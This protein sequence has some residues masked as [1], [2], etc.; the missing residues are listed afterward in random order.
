M[1]AAAAP[2]PLQA[3]RLAARLLLA[4]GFWTLWLALALLL[5]AQLYIASTDELSLPGFVRRS[6]EARLAASGIRATFGRTHFDPTGRIVVENLA[7]TLPGYSEPQVTARAVVGRIDPWQLLGDRFEPVE[8][9]VTGLSVHVPGLLSL[10]GGGDQILRDV[11]AALV[12]RGDELK[13]SYLTGR[14]GDMPVSLQGTLR[15][16]LGGWTKEGPAPLPVAE[17]LAR[18]YPQLSRQ[19]EAALAGLRTFD[20]PV[21][22]VDLASAAGPG[23][24]ARVDFAA[25]SYRSDAPV[26]VRLT[27]LRV[28]GEAQ[29][30]GDAPAPA[31]IALTAGAGTFSA[32]GTVEELAAWI[33]GSLAGAGRAAGAPFLRLQAAQLVAVRIGAAGLGVDRPIA[34]VDLA[35]WPRIGADLRGLL[36]DQRIA[37]QADV[38]PGA[39]AARVRFSGALASPAIDFVGRQVHRDLRTLVAYSTP[40][41]A[42]GEAQFGPA[43]KFARAAA[44]IELAGLTARGVRIDAAHGS[45]EFDGRTLRS[46]DAFAQLGENFARG[47]FTE[48]VASHDYRFLLEGRLRP[49]DITPWIAGAWWPEFFGLFDFSAE[50]VAANADIRGCFTD[51]RQAAD[52][53]EVTVGQPGFRGLKFDRL[54]ARIFSRPQF[55]DGLEFELSRGGGTASGTFARRYDLDAGALQSLDLAVQSTLDLAPLGPLLSASGSP[56]LDAFVF[57]RPPQVGLTAHFDGQAAPA[58][59][60]EVLRLDVRT[61]EPISYNDFPFDRIAFV[62]EVNDADIRLPKLE[63]KVAGGT[64]TGSARVWGD[65]AARRLKVDAALADASLGQAIA[66]VQEFSARRAHRPSTPPTRFVQ[67]KTS[68]RVNAT[69]AAEGNFGDALSL[70]GDGTIALDGEN[71]HQIRLLGL[72]SALLPVTELRFTA[73]RASFRLDGPRLVFPDVRVTGANSALTGS[74]TYYLDRSVLDFKIRVNPFQESKSFPQQLMDTVVAPLSGALELRL[75]GKI[76]KPSLVFANG[77]T[78]FL[79]SLGQIGKPAPAPPAPLA[80]RPAP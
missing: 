23:A 33:Q 44:R 43:W 53:V 40:I 11:D 55:T 63:A 25:R 67:E 8:L 80:D 72:F 66:V 31:R 37:V 69:L 74:G 75:T 56:I 5:A 13:V 6:L 58:G 71:L 73:A 52:F 59:P 26:P 39:G 3:A 78:N 41:A 19:A 65:G 46:P 21:L 30:G 57:A 18:I 35:N 38:D 77:P 28:H 24:L 2:Q 7:L 50:P 20:Q 68:V 27:G 10:P 14:F 29:V 1:S 54:H 60:H 64:L 48:D 61:D 36:W 4:L 79:R 9:R 42:T 34:T 76:D 70:K 51:G 32:D 62:A 12:P 45:V 49:L 15:L 47:S 16:G 17:A 22:Q